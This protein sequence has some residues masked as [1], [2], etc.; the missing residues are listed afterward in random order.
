MATSEEHPANR[1]L[2]EL[3]AQ[4]QHARERYSLYKAKSYSSRPTSPGRLRELKQ[5]AERAGQREERAKSDE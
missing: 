3:E 2:R 1:R 5:D 4:A